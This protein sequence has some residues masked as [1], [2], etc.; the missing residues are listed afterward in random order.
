MELQGPGSSKKKLEDNEEGNTTVSNGSHATNENCCS[1]VVSD[2]ISTVKCSP[3]VLEEDDNMNQPL[4]ADELRPLKK[5]KP[6][7]SENNC[8]SEVNNGLFNFSRLFNF[9]W[10]QVCSCYLQFIWLGLG[11]L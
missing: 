9:Y 8:S 10:N 2:S 3:E 11:L 4:A 6:L 1:E 5:A 7:S